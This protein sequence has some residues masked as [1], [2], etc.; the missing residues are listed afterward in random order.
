[1]AG[2][3]A[4]AAAGFDAADRVGGEQRAPHGVDECCVRVPNLHKQAGNSM[5][6]EKGLI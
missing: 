4:F 6:K 1:M 2:P 5:D 3:G